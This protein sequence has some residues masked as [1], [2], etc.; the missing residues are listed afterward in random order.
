M[1]NCNSILR[2]KNDIIVNRLKQDA[3][4]KVNLTNPGLQL[5]SPCGHISLQGFSLLSMETK[6][7]HEIVFEI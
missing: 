6:G 2:N 7:L 5:L 1:Q 3:K 4:D